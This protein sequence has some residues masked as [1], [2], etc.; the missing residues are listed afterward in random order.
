[1]AQSHPFRLDKTGA[2]LNIVGN[3]LAKTSRV[4][5]IIVQ[6]VFIA[7]YSYSIYAYRNYGVLLGVNIFL[8]AI[9]LVYFIFHVIAISA[10]NKKFKKVVKN[11]IKKSIVYTKLI[12]KM[13]TIGLSIYEV[14]KVAYT[15]LKLI[16]LIVAVVLFFVQIIFEAIKLLIEK[17]TKIIWQGIQM[18]YEELKNSTAYKTITKVVDTC[19]NPVAV[20]V[21]SVNKPLKAV[22]KRTEKIE[23]QPQA[24]EHEAEPNKTQRK[25]YQKAD[26]LEEIRE[27]KK[28]INEQKKTSRI[29]DA[30]E[31][32]KNTVKKVINKGDEK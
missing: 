8:L 18:D 28:Q 2:A 3:N 20:L 24:L 31:Q 1:M 9:S 30:V 14:T 4:I 12:I 26:E 25:I 13:F 16:M 29:I 22:L 21:E 19:Q 27:Q 7:L 6:I 11:K 5:D 10:K 15:D 32:F 23:N 17:Y